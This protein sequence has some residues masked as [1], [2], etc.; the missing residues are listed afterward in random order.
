MH[1]T[2]TDARGRLRTL[3]IL[4][5]KLDAGRAPNRLSAYA[6]LIGERPAQRP[7]M[8]ADLEQLAK[9]TPN[10]GLAELLREACDVL[11]EALRG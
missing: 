3:A 7:E 1:M 4:A 2:R 10:A 11:R 5:A 9:Q 6:I 8:L